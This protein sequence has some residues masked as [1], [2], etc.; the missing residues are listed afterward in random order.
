MTAIVG[1]G[2]GGDVLTGGSWVGG[3]APGVGDTCTLA[4]GATYTHNTGST[5][6][7]GDSA[8]PTTHAIRTSGSAGTGVLNWNS[9]IELLG[10][11][12]QGNANWACSAGGSVLFDHA[13][14]E[15][16]WQVCD[17]NS[18]HKA[19]TFTGTFSAPCIVSSNAAGVNG[20]FISGGFFNGG[21]VRGTH[22]DFTRIGTATNDAFNLDYTFTNANIFVSFTD[23]RFTSCGRVYCPSNVIANAVIALTRVEFASSLNAKAFRVNGQSGALGSGT[24]LLQDVSSDNDIEILGYHFT[25]DEVVVHNTVTRRS[26]IAENP[27]SMTNIASRVNQTA[28]ASV[29]IDVRPRQAATFRDW[30]Y[31]SFGNSNAHLAQFTLTN[32]AADMTLDGLIHHSEYSG[33]Q[34]D[35]DHTKL[36][37]DPSSLRTVNVKNSIGLANAAGYSTGCFVAPLTGFQHLHITGEHN[38]FVA[39]AGPETGFNAQDANT[40]VAYN[41]GTALYTSI[42]SNLVV[43]GTALRA[44]I[45]SRYFGTPNQQDIADPAQVCNNWVQDPASGT[46]LG[47]Q[48]DAWSFKQTATSAYFTTAVAGPTYYGDPQ[49]RDRTVTH[50]TWDAS[51]GGAGTFA[52]AFTRLQKRCSRSNPAATDKVANLIAYIRWGWTPTNIAVKAAHDSVNNG[53]IGAVEGVAGDGGAYIRQQIPHL[54]QAGRVSVPQGNRGSLTRR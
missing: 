10:I 26:L 53:W 23:C 34:G 14:T 11:V 4:N 42:K 50:A 28:G 52:A 6:R 16:T 18:Q 48:G 45:L 32:L 27:L 21:N 8:N 38:S 3:V 22:T 9:P 7:V 41:G 39:D 1:V 44:C 17:A 37:G 54:R 12:L 43:S 47:G 46:F 33:G 29:S 20:R 25:F 49:L 2:G 13:S 51:L 40:G 30:Y 35:G 5:W 19:L 15:L 36:Q 24:R 31:T